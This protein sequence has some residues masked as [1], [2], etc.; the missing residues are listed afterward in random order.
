GGAARLLGI[1]PGEV[2]DAHVALEDIWGSCAT[3]LR[4][5]LCAAA[6]QDERFRILEH[7]LTTRLLRAFNN[8]SVTELALLLLEQPGV[9]VGE[10][11]QRIGLSHRRFIEIF[12]EDVGMTPK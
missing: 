12:S 4:E 2:Q 9:E 5:R 7:D 11:A 6:D 8:R 1:R 3:E 10:V